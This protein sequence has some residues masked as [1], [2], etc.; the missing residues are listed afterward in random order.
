[1]PKS[2]LIRFIKALSSLRHRKSWGPF[3]ETYEATRFDYAFS[4][5]WSQAGEDLALMPILG[6]I[7]NGRYLDVGAHHPSRFS[8]T[9][10]LF[11]SGWSGVNVDGNVDLLREFETQRPK[12]LS[13]NFCVG[14]QTSY[15]LN[16]F[17]ET[18]ISTVDSAWKSKFLS[19]DNAILESR[20]VQGITL[21][22]LI[23]KYFSNGDLDFL[24]IDIE[25]ADLD[26]LISADF[27]NLEFKLWPTWVL[28][29]ANAPLSVASQSAAVQHLHSF[30]YQIYLVLP[31]A[32][33]LQKPQTKK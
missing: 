29:E 18:A 24:N 6:K 7:T 26:A 9:R 11:R 32:C 23:E 17:N 12:D 15:T 28:I 33:L 21:R 3:T 16:V 13:L 8:V 30:G 22:T 14:T 27:L 1:M 31:F 20:E 4:V 10:H 2:K 25:G 19:E 5:S